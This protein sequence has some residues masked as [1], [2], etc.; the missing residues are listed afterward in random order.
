MRHPNQRFCA[1]HGSRLTAPTSARL[2]A[3]TPDAGGAE[4]ANPHRKPASLCGRQDEPARETS[5]ANAAIAQSPQPHNLVAA[6]RVPSKMLGH[7]FAPRVV[8]V[9]VSCAGLV[10]TQF[11]LPS[12]RLVKHVSFLPGAARAPTAPA[13]AAGC[14]HETLVAEP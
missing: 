4:H 2:P 8:A 1:W 3:V 7:S 6:W 11:C 14:G 13:H 5:Q 9:C 12:T 10:R